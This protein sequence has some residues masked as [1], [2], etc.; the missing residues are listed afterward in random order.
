MATIDEVIENAQD[1]AEDLRGLAEDMVEDASQIAQGRAFTNVRDLEFTL[2]QQEDAYGFIDEDVP[3]EFTDTFF[4]PIKDQYVDEVDFEA[5]YLI[6]QPQF[7][8]A[9]D[10]LNTDNLFDIDLPAWDIPDFTTAPPSINTNLLFPTAPVITLPPDPTPSGDIF[11]VPDVVAPIFDDQMNLNAVST[12]DVTA[13]IADEFTITRQQLVDAAES[14]ANNWMV[15]HCPNY[16]TGMAELEARI[17]SAMQGGNAL[18]EAWEQAIYD[19]ALIRTTDEQHRAQLAL[20]ED[21]ARRGFAVPPGAVMGG[22]SRIRYE[23]SRNTADISAQVA[24][25]RAKIELQHLQFGMQIST[26]LRQHFSS[27]MQNYMQLALSGNGIA[28]EYAKDIGRWAAEIFNQ[29]VELY[30]LEIQRYQAEAQV[31]AVRLE[32]AFAM[33]KVFEVEIEAEKLKIEVD[34]NAIALYEAKIQGE[35]SKIEIYNSQLQA[36]RTQLESEGQKLAIY[37]SQVKAYATRVGAKE[38]EYNAYRAAIQGDAEKV[39]AYSAEVRAYS[40][41]VSAAGTKVDADRAISQSITE[42]NRALLDRRDSG[43]KLYM[44]DID[45][46]GTRFSSSVEAQKAVLASYT[47]RVEAKLKAMLNEYEYKRLD[48]QAAVARVETNLRA[49]IADVESSVRSIVAQANVTNSGANIISNMA[50]AVLTTNN[51]ILTK[52]DT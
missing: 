39:N 12:I 22:L 5:P 32:S 16:T 51:T 40:E 14:Y 26:T 37:E 31:Y 38:S 3:A 13:R 21:Y 44:A 42:Y 4:R 34:R 29:G 18:D 45:A 7:P 24:V 8:N 47:T 6:A 30:K 52:E 15:Q 2:G 10:A 43:I 36:I 49:Q 19:R 20:T 41:G 48:L 46:E 1:Y 17:S 27:A 23:Q 35:Q 28:L 9:P 11:D 25:E 33:I 50:S